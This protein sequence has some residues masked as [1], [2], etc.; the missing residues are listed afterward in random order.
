MWQLLREARLGEVR[1]WDE[2]DRYLVLGRRG[3]WQ[4]EFLR[5]SRPQA[6]PDSV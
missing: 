1:V 5:Q 2:V 4:V 6:G 3:G